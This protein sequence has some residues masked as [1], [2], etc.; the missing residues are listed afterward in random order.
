M[1]AWPSL[2]PPPKSLPTH[3]DLKEG[4]HNEKLH[5]PLLNG[6]QEE[7]YVPIPHVGLDPK[8]ILDDTAVTLS[9]VEENLDI[10]DQRGI[11][12]RTPVLPSHG[13]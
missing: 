5:Q 8:E 12:A 4:L 6:T 2:M 7:T 1:Q 11:F 10:W 3:L 13:T 9:L